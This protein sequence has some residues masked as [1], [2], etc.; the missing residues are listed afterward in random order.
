MAVGGAA[1]AVVAAAVAAAAGAAL[2]LLVLALLGLFRCRG[3]RNA[4]G[5]LSVL[6]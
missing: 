1:L 4:P 5:V 2:R 3:A 6:P